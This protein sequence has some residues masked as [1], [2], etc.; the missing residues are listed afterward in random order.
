MVVH[1]NR[2]QVS[3]VTPAI[4]VNLRWCWSVLLRVRL[5]IL[6]HLRLSPTICPAQYLMEPKLRERPVCR[7]QQI[8]NSS[9]HS[10][11]GQLDLS[12]SS[13]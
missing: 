11:R 2:M 1:F 4:S 6:L 10:D 8:T 12:S 9:A 3:K 7:L 5:P 13:Q